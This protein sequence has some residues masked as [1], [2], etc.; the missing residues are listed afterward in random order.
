[1]SK[2][3]ADAMMSEVRK[4]IKP[5]APYGKVPDHLREAVKQM[6]AGQNGA[7]A[8]ALSDAAK[9]LGNMMEQMADAQDLKSTIEALKRAQLAVGSGNS[10][11]NSKGPPRAGKGG[12][13]GRG[14]G[15][16][17][18]ESDWTDQ[19]EQTDRWDNSG[20]QRP[21]TDPRGLTDR[22]Q[23]QTPDGMEAT[24]VKGQF[25]PGSQMPSITLRGVS[26]KGKSS[27]DLKA[28]VT[29]AQ[30]EAQSAI[31]NDQVPRG[32][33]SAVKDYFNDLNDEH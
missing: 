25:S 1:M 33:Q 6:E 3:Q 12:K 20:V 5:A 24:S 22:G 29:A 21:D 9:E 15:T 13:P 18:D 27:V 4:A 31:A 30:S 32:Y 26:I 7:A 8:Q 2:E 23:G 11:G 16:W 10:W 17:A 19:P 28:V 14:V